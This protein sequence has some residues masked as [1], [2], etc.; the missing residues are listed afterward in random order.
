[1]SD[2]YLTMYNK[3]IVCPYCG[4]KHEANSENYADQDEEVEREC[5]ACQKEFVY[6]TDY[7]ITFCTYKKERAE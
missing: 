6:I 3:D 1:M 4:R 2:E 7:D 5:Y